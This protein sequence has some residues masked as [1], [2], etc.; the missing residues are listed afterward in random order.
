MAVAVPYRPLSKVGRFHY[1]MI[2]LFDKTVRHLLDKHLRELKERL[3]GRQTPLTIVFTGHS[4]GAAIA[5]MSSWYFA[6]RTGALI[7]QG[8]LIVRT[9]TF[10]SPSWGNAAAYEDMHK[11][12]ALTQEVNLDIDPVWTLFGE[13]SLSGLLNKKPFQMQ[14]CTL[15][16][17]FCTLETEVLHSRDYSPEATAHVALLAAFDLTSS[18]GGLKIQLHVQDMD[19][20]EVASSVPGEPPFSGRVWTRPNYRPTTWLKKLAAM[21]FRMEDVDMLLLDPGISHFAGY[22]AAL[23]LMAGLLDEASYGSGVAA[24]FSDNSATTGHAQ[25][26]QMKTAHQKLRTILRRVEADRL[27][28]D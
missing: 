15:S 16:M 7:Q 28:E 22:T 17:K 26:V 11:S 25:N 27:A 3:K 12:G 1:G 18:L 14:F 8:R 10:G 24:P 5:E 2:Y 23:T 6:K 20:V 4:L 19:Q 21:V 9:V 13:E